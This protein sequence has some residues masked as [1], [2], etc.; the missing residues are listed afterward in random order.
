MAKLY[1]VQELVCQQ[2]S[3][4]QSRRHHYVQARQRG[5]TYCK[6]K[7]KPVFTKW[8][9]GRCA[10]LS[11]TFSCAINAAVL[12]CRRPGQFIHFIGTV[13]QLVS[14]VAVSCRSSAVSVLCSV[15]NLGCLS[16]I[17][18]SSHP[19]CF[20]ILGFR[21]PDPTKLFQNCQ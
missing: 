2:S 10:D 8:G 6:G 4:Q 13:M 21:I 17:R 7:Q 14:H 16:R 15:A 12:S 5:G 1:F 9:W 18:I 19:R 3:R 11:W 20:R